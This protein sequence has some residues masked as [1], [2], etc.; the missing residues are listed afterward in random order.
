MP[1]K[2]YR[3]SLLGSNSGRNAGDLAILEAVVREVSRR[4]PG[5]VFEVPTT[6]PGFIRRHFDGREV[7]PVS[8][9]PW[10]LSL[11]LLGLP[12]FRSLARC[13][14]SLIMDG[15]IFDHRLFN[16]AF[17]FLITLV[18]L[19]P[20]VRMIRR[21]MVC[22]E[23]G[24]GPLRTRS[25][26][27]F[28]RMVGEACDLIMVR[29]ED[30]L[31]LMEEVG[32]T[33]TP[34]EVY[35]DAAFVN[36]PAPPSEVQVMVDRLDLKG[37]LMAGLNLTRYGGDW[38]KK[39]KEFDR[40]AFQ[41]QMSALI[42]EFSTSTG[43]VVILTGTQIMDREYLTEVKEMVRRPDSVRIVSNAELTPAQ[44]AGLMGRMEIF[45]GMRLHSLIL[46]SSVKTPILG[47]TYAPKVKS[48]LTV[49][50]RPVLALDLGALAPGALLKVM[51][52]FWEERSGERERI[53]PLVDA[54]KERAHAGFDR[55]AE[56]YL[57]I[58]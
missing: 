47:L 1:A 13:D 20:W 2:P 21:P 24:I 56:S 8:I 42:D 4:R 49:L 37:R 48:L 55:L 43:A 27:R 16:P 18:P 54:L 40:L 19:V 11:R 35:A 36:E 30:S 7:V 39:G 5:T 22:F 57:P 52:A 50:G 12:V 23:V 3:L 45:V 53:S 29:E 32:V 26:R 10:N 33:G 6:N 51:T 38:M 9:M 17:N 28:A 25:G 58:T 44:L 15:I 31:R 34:M 41:R 14:L 46:A